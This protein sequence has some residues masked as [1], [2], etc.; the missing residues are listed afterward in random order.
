MVLVAGGFGPSGYLTN[1]ELYN[2]A[3]GT[4]TATGSLNTARDSHTATLLPSGMVLVAGGYNSSGGVLTNAELYNPANGTWTATDSLNNARDSQTATLLPSGMVLVAG[5]S[6]SGSLAG[7]T[8]A[9][10]YIPTNGIWLTNGSLNTGRYFH[11]A[12]LLP[13]G[14][15]LVAGGYYGGLGLNVLASAELYNPA[16][17]TWTAT[18]SLNTPRY[19]HTATLLPNGMV[20]VAAGGNYYYGWLTSAELYNPANATWTATGSFNTPRFG[21]T[22]TLLPNGMVLV[23]GGLENYGNAFFTAELYNSANGTWTATGSLNT[24]RY[25][26]TATLLP[27][28]MVLVA[29][30]YNASGSL[31]SAELYNIGLG[32]SSSWQPQIASVASLLSPG[33]SLVLTGSQFRG[34]SEGSGGN[35]TQDSPADFPVLQLRRLDNEQ[36][37]FL[38]T[39]NW[40]ANSVTSAPVT[41]FPPGYALVTV[42]VNGIPSTA[43]ILFNGPYILFGPAMLPSGGFQFTFGNT[44]GLT[45]TPLATTDLSLPL[46]NWTALGG[47]TEISPGQF[48]FTDPLAT[49]GALRFYTVRSP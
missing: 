3:N 22:A 39:T 36:T 44:P 46:S 21:H 38:L 29:G 1:A 4:W 2:P 9:E 8:S 28:G 31:T 15:V 26:H 45:F 42:F 7:P 49:N 13:N 40:S 47:M 11:T 12:T 17:G 35:G 6:S 37:V 10:L 19:L 14:M 5:G 41:N 20:L 27:N 32:F 34:I 18:G 25:W 48:Q 24:A 16:N 23:A 30:G 33:G 43:G